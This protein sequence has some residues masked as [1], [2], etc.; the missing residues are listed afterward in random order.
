M[1]VLLLARRQELGMLRAELLRCEGFSVIFPAGRKEALAAIQKREFDAV[2]LSY[3][4][5]SETAEELAELVRQKCP[6]CPLVVIAVSQ[7]AD[8]KIQPDEIV[9]AEQEPQAMLDALRRVERRK[10]RRVK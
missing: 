7:H 9:L 10:M 1:T 4:L 3:S 5:S 6:G 8:L 2:L